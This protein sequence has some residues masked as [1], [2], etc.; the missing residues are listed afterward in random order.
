MNEVVI[1]EQ[2]RVNWRGEV[3]PVQYTPCDSMETA[4]YLLEHSM[5]E[6]KDNPSVMVT[7]MNDNMYE[8][9]HKVPLIEDDTVYYMHIKTMTPISKR[10][11]DEGIV[12]T[13]QKA[14]EQD[15]TVDIKLD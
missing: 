14:A 12:R 9:R 11:V 5:E 3:V 1:V 15:Y 8:I 10:D 6:Y 7:K 13:A 2:C 4:K